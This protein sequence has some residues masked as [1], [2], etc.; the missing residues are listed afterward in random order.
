MLFLK[1][2]VCFFPW[3]FGYLD[4]WLP[5]HVELV[6]AWRCLF[7]SG[8]AD[9]WIRCYQQRIRYLTICDL[10]ICNLTAL[11]LPLLPCCHYLTV[12]A[13]WRCLFLSGSTDLWIHCYQQRICYLTTCN[14]TMH[15]LKSGVCFFPWI[16]GYLDP[17]LPMHVE[18]VA[19]RRCLFLSRSTDLWIHCYQQRIRYLTICDLTIC[20]LTAITLLL[21]PWCRYLTVVAPWRCLI[22]ERIYG[23]IDIL[24]LTVDLLPLPLVT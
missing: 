12:V 5:M 22:F 24:L 10:T 17:W 3:I 1:T 9:L 4:P 7:L 20:N 2:G 16:F 15:F 18:L 19:P 11:T 13:P 14:L 8:S 21:L 23:S 6:A